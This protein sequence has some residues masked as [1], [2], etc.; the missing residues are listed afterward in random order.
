MH[1]ILNFTC[2]GDSVV[3]ASGVPDGEEES[4]AAEILKGNPLGVQPA[5]LKN[6]HIKIP[7]LVCAGDVFSAD[8]A[9]CCAALPTEGDDAKTIFSPAL[10]KTFL[11]GFDAA[12]AEARLS[13]A[14]RAKI[15]LSGACPSVIFGGCEYFIFAPDSDTDALPDLAALTAASVCRAGALLVISGD[16]I[17]PDFA[18]KDGAFC[19]FSAGSAA[20]ALAFFESEQ[21]RD[22]YKKTYRFPKGERT[23]EMKRFLSEAFD[24]MLKAEVKKF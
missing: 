6:T 3:I 20:I 12:R 18:Q 15:N 8:A 11:L 19:A 9:L 17:Q 4:T 14:S 5:F 13:L 10:E 22:F 24:C 2:G 23:V 1:A 21:N 16:Q 7:T